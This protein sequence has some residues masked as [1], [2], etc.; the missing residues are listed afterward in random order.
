MSSVSLRLDSDTETYA[1]NALGV[2]Y[3]KRVKLA[4]GQFVYASVYRYDGNG[5]EGGGGTTM[6]SI[7]RAR[8]P[9]TWNIDH[10]AK[11]SLI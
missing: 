8:P 11:V 3:T 10:W 9:P 2:E 7:I 4:H 1:Y 6:Y 5:G